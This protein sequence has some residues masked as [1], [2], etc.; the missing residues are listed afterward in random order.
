MEELPSLWA[1]H[2]MDL[3]TS[4][5]DYFPYNILLIPTFF[6]ELTMSTDRLIMSY[7]RSFERITEQIKPLCEF[8]QTFLG[9]LFESTNNSSI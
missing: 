6:R 2:L 7:P 8:T 1:Q 5:G 9:S 3:V 4:A